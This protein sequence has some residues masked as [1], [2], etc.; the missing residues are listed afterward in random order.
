[1]GKRLKNPKPMT[2][3][4]QVLRNHGNMLGESED[5]TVIC[6]ATLCGVTYDVAHSALSKAGRRSNRGVRMH[7][8]RL[9]IESLG[10]DIEVMKRQHFISRYPGDYR[11]VTCVTSRHPDKFNHVWRDGFNYLLATRSHALAVK[12]GVTHDWSRNVSKKVVT[13]WKVVKKAE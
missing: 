12:N 10:F 4:Y 9:A 6:V 3:D 11:N 2:D 8:I 13:I 7:S 1:M 5:C